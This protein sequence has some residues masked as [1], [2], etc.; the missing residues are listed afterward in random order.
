MKIAIFTQPLH[1]NYGGILQAYAL[2]IFLQKHGHDVVVVNR[3]YD[4]N[5]T[6]KL[7]LRR[8]ASV[9]MSFIRSVLLKK[10]EYI[11]MNPFSPF[12]HNKWHGYDI[13]PFVPE[14]INLTKEIRSS[15]ALK[16][17]LKKNRFD[18]Y[19]VGSDQVWRPCYSPNITDFFLKQVPLDIK[20]KRLAYS[21]SFGTDQWE[22][23]DEETRECAALAK[24]FDAISV[25]EGSGVKLCH[26]KL[27]I[28]GAVQVLDPTML[29]NVDD[30]IKLFE[31]SNEPIFQSNVFCYVLDKN[32]LVESIM[33]ALQADGYTSMC[34]DIYQSA[35]NNNPRPYQMPVTEWLRSIYMSDFI[36]TDS[37]H[38]CVF[39]I[40]FKKP[41][42]VMGNHVRGNTRFDSLLNMFC[43]KSRFVDS[44][45][46]FE[47]HKAVLMDVSDLNATEQ[48]LSKYRKISV[49]FFK[50]VG[51]I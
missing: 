1:T 50:S 47:R 20:S 5:I 39:S 15:K 26:E 31:K 45:T 40:L 49:N 42:V 23:S 16:K 9:I 37:F 6:I 19:I 48:V 27:G 28:N 35:T 43:L 51:L 25:R 7:L 24:L 38:A 29:L 22:F 3:D 36:V 11:V 17:Y 18:C 30:Y 4:N 13:L 2:Q 44:F 8:V 10:N 32:N 46:K 14:Y 34:A 41:F 33:A 12:Y 21:A